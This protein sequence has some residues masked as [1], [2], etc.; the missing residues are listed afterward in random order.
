MGILDRLF[1]R[2]KTIKDLTVGELQEEKVRLEEQERRVTKTIEKIEADKTALFKKGAAAGSKRE[3]VVFA[4]KIKELDEFVKEHD[5]QSAM[6]S[7]QIRV[8][9]RLVSMKRKETQLR[10]MIGQTATPQG[11]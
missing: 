11:S 2:K 1:G 10:K 3:Q 7:K 6:L 9:N 4:R 5:R 8:V